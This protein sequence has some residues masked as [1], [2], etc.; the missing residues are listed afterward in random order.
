MSATDLPPHLDI[1]KR[2]GDQQHLDL[3]RLRGQREQ[4]GE[5]V[6]DALDKTFINQSVQFKLSHLILIL[7]SRIQIQ[8]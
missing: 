4:D 6:V 1:A 8:I 5:D 3:L 7:L 2:Q